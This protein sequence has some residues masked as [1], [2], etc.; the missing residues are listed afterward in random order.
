MDFFNYHDHSYEM[1]YSLIFLSSLFAEDCLDV[2]RNNFDLIYGV[3]NN[4]VEFCKTQGFFSGRCLLE[5]EAAYAKGVDIAG[6]I[7][8]TCE[9]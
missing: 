5:A 6:D 8:Y 1:F 7:F 2:W 3:Y 4:D 9:E